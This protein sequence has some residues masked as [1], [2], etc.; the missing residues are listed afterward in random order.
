MTL[1]EALAGL[2]IWL[3]L[4]TSEERK[5]LEGHVT[6]QTIYSGAEEERRIIGEEGL[7]QTTCDELIAAPVACSPALG[8]RR[9]T[10]LGS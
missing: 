8:V 2:D 4:W 5:S 1:W 6:L 10:M 9:K 7:A 3:E